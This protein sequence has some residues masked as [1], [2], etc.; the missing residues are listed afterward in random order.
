MLNICLCRE[1][2]YEF[3]ENSAET[4]QGLRWQPVSRVA[5]ALSGIVRAADHKITLCMCFARKASS[6]SIY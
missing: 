2:D 6:N 3:S 4:H 5:V 1:F